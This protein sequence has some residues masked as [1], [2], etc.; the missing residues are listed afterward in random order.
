MFGNVR[1]RSGGGEAP[2]TPVAGTFPYCDGCKP[3]AR[4][5]WNAGAGMR[6]LRGSPRLVML[7]PNRPAL[8]LAPMEGVTDAPMRA[9]QGATGAFSFMVTEFI[10]VSADS[11][12]ERQFRREVPELAHGAKTPNGVTVLVQLLGGD[13]DRMAESAVA[14]CAAGAPGIDLNFG[15]PA[16]TVNRHD[17]GASLLRH[18][19]RIREIVGAVRAAV[20]A[21]IPVSAKLRLGWD[22]IDAIDLNAEMAAEGGSS[23]ITIHARTRTQGYRPPV[24]WA[25]IGRVRANLTIPVV[26]N[27][28]IWTI[29]DFHECQTVTGCVHFMIGRSALANPRLPSQIAHAL[30]LRNPQ[31]NCARD[32][33]SQFQ[34]LLQWMAYYDGEVTSYAVLKL[35]QWAKLATAQ[36][37][38]PWFDAVKEARTTEDFLAQLA[39]AS[40]DAG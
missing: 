21:E 11:L 17:G 25:A 32:W 36:G 18:P 3:G 5:G 31:E 23:W 13:P 8:I 16:K 20:P 9:L 30:G 15:C 39:A 29:D 28:D 38:F 37:N 27:G 14:A 12:P 6:H 1:Y 2:R 40:A 4:V 26:A 35:K 33:I 7:V 10:R 24:N 19:T 34:A 22:S